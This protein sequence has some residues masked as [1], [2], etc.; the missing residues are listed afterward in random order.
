MSLKKYTRLFPVLIA[1]S[2][3]IILIGGSLAAFA[4]SRNGEYTST[5]TPY[6]LKR[7][8]A[9]TTYDVELP[10]ITNAAT[11]SRQRAESMPTERATLTYRYSHK[12]QENNQDI[13][14]DE[15]GNLYNYHELTGQ[16][17]G[18]FYQQKETRN[19]LAE[20]TKEQVLSF[21]EQYL[22]TMVPH[23]EQ[24]GLAS[25]VEIPSEEEITVPNRYTIS[26]GIPIGDFFTSDRIMMHL[27]PSGDLIDVNFP[28]TSL[29]TDM[30][31]KEKEKLAQR[32]PSKEQVKQYAEEKMNDKYG[33][34]LVGVEISSIN[35]RKNGSGY[36]IGMALSVDVSNGD[37]VVMP[38]Y[39]KLVY[40]VE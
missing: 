29:Y 10:S 38:R 34:I 1:L 36:E 24:Y 28:Q 26:Y 23:A 9:R 18:I 15:A 33:E 7:E 31:E 6:I 39:E 5:D 12:G 8:D 25:F 2:L 22:S 20:L 17:I 4:I 14:S 27:S 40:T 32:L 21:A 37:G 11:F 13:Y 16:L 19:I 3:T 30:T 35:L